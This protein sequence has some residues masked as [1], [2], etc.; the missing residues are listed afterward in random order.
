MLEYVPV[1]QCWNF[2]RC[3][4]V[5]G[6]GFLHCS[7]LEIKCLILWPQILS[8]TFISALS[9]KVFVPAFSTAAEQAEEKLKHGREGGRAG[10]GRPRRRERGSH[11]KFLRCVRMFKSLPL[12]SVP[13]ANHR[14]ENQPDD[15][16]TGGN[17]WGDNNAFLYC[18]I[19]F[20]NS[21]KK[22]T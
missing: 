16:A 10:G 20:Q 3:L 8:S 21:P 4:A 2:S 22:E 1:R 19:L 14:T 7:I 9:L 17:T 5:R 11:G 13:S 18:K 12:R 6:Y 15:S